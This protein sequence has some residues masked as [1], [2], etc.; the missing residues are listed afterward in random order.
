VS[1]ALQAWCN[2]EYARL[3]MLKRSIR[4]SQIYFLSSPVSSSCVVAMKT[5]SQRSFAPR[6]FFPNLKTSVAY[7][8]S[9]NSFE[10][11]YPLATKPLFFIS[12]HEK[13]DGA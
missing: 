5:I 3:R 13:R 12:L 10:K 6:D 11:L 9:T 1:S 4:C 7:N 2:G 8:Y